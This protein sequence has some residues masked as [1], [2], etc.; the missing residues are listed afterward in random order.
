MPD[1]FMKIGQPEYLGQEEMQYMFQMFRA[2]H[3][4]CR[5]GGGGVLAHH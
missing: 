4:L 5:W 1:I 3:A 2:Y